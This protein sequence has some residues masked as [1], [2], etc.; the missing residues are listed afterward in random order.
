MTAN[1]KTALVTGGAKRL[2]AGVCMALA[3]AGFRVAIHHHRSQEAALE[4]AGAIDALHGAGAA[5]AFHA[6]LSNPAERG[7]L[8]KAVTQTFGR[9][10]LLVNNASVFGKTPPEEFSVEDLERYHK[11]HVEA[12]IEL[13]LLARE[14]L[15]SDG[16][17]RIINILDIFADFPRKGYLSYCAT[18]AGLKAATRQLA[19]EFA[20]KILVNGVA[21]GA[22]IM[23]E[24]G[25]DAATLAR[26]EARIPLGRFGQVDD[27]AGAVVFLAGAAYITGQVI[28]VDGGRSINI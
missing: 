4:L 5:V 22:I 9:L 11:I 10:D 14:A 18:K 25:M 2:G 21:P 3:K 7:A 27:I 13:S 26:I 12:P 8:M 6:D 15:A 1:A 28:V 19:L 20:P 23:P 24:G 17:G 16:V